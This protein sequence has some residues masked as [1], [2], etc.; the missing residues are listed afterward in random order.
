LPVIEVVEL[1]QIAARLEAAVREAGSLAHA[2]F[3]TAL[4]TWTKGPSASPVSEADIGC[5]KK[6]SMTRLV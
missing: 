4:K 6:A 1:A 3:G 5:R 2:M